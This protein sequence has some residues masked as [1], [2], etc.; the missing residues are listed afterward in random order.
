MKFYISAENASG[1]SFNN[2]DSFLNYLSEEIEKEM[3]TGK[4]CFS[5]TIENE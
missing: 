4:E 5:I 1:A 3:S 2:K